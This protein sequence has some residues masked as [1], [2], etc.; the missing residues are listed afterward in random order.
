MRQTR[1]GFTRFLN[2]KAKELRITVS[3]AYFGPVSIARYENGVLP[4]VLVLK[5][6]AR[7]FGIS[8]ETLEGMAG[9]DKWAQ[10]E[11]GIRKRGGK[12]PPNSL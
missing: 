11:A 12:G 3:S 4:G 10:T 9:R 7:I 2:A 6:L 8:S 5:T 1:A